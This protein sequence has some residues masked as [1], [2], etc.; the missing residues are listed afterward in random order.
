MIKVTQLECGRRDLSH[1]RRV[2]TQEPSGAHRPGALLWI[3][4]VSL[5]LSP[6]HG[7]Q[8]YWSPGCEIQAPESL[9]LVLLAPALTLILI[10]FFLE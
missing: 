4:G 9:H 2:S 6:S 8:V 10:L 7:L 1:G 3:A 5:L